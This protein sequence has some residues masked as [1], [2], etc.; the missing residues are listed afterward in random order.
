MSDSQRSDKYNCSEV[1]KKVQA[2][3]DGQLTSEEA[4]LFEDHL[5]Y[6]L[7][8]DKKVEFEKK[9]KSFLKIKAAKE[10]CP[11]SLK[12]ELNKIVKDD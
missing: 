2:Y 12:I 11:D 5:D 4:I 6:C 1:K 8:C 3:I 7:P 10:P 9:F